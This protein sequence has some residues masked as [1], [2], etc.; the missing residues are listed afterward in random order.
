MGIADTLDQETSRVGLGDSMR[1]PRISASG[2]A[3]I[4]QQRLLRAGTSGVE[5]SDPSML[6]TSSWVAPGLE[7]G[8]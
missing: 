8:L 2:A 5:G 3:A 4:A 6:G 1:P 7:A